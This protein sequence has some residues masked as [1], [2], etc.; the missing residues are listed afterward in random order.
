MHDT[1]MDVHGAGAQRSDPKTGEA[2]SRGLQ[3]DM[4]RVKNYVRLV[5]GGNA[6]LVTS[7]T[8]E[9]LNKYTQSES[10]TKAYSNNPKNDLN[11]NGNNRFINQLDKDGDGKVSLLEFKNG[12]RRFNHLDKN[13]DGYI[14]A[15]EA[16]TGPPPNGR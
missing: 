4:I 16:P 11:T 1:I 10:A 8:A 5:R 6:N 14:T 2:M 13:H 3:G 15:D 7:I 12:E 9:N